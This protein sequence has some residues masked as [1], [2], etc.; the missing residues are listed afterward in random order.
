MLGIKGMP[1]TAYHPQTDG[2]TERVNQELEV[3]LRFYINYQQDDW[4]RWLDQAEFV[5]N[6]NFHEAIQNTPFE[7]MH[8]LTPWSGREEGNSDKSPGANEWKLRLMEARKRAQEALENARTSM[9]KHYDKKK[10][11]GRDFKEG[12]KVWL[13]A[14]N[15]KTYRPG[16]KL[17]NKKLVPFTIL[18]KVRNSAYRL[19][20]RKSWNRVHPV[21]NEILLSP[22]HPPN[23]GSQS[24]PEP[25][26]PI[27]QEG[28]PE[29]NVEEVLAARK[30]GRGIQYLVKWEDYGHEE[31]TW[32]PRRNLDNA[33]EALMDFYNKYPMAV[34]RLLHV[35]QKEQKDIQVYEKTGHRGVFETKTEDR[36]GYCRDSMT[37]RVVR[38]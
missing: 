9:K 7:L 16:K 24:K 6:S 38:A 22:H 21:F 1:S 14:K 30:R 3:Y 4:S 2:Q 36:K 37:I 19:Q 29:Y 26:G 31:N 18:E 25:P 5:Q 13:D 12:E 34:R 20:L 17:D 28:Y 8:G 33:Q 27:L 10:E 35:L 32:E 23:F 15:L 11:K